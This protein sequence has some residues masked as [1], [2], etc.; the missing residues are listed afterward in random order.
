MI[1]VTITTSADTIKVVA[2][3]SS[4]NNSAFRNRG[5]KFDRA[6]GWIL[7]NTPTVQ[8]LLQELWGTSETLVWA[9]VQ[10]GDITGRQIAQVGG[11]VIASRRE[12]DKSVSM[13]R[14]VQV[15]NGHW[16]DSGGSV[17]NPAVTGSDDLTIKVLVRKDFAEA[18][19][20]EIIEETVPAP[21]VAESPLVFTLVGKDFDEANI[22][23]VAPAAVPAPVV[24]ENPLANYTDEQIKAEFL[25]RGLSL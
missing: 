18:N 19:K 6:R 14:G 17:K 5:G 7:P 12:R 24:V 1:Q 20:L 21:V 9:R 22:D 8:D 2:P 3:F 25:R 23:E 16:F 13:A 4:K 11:Y 15:E 10:G